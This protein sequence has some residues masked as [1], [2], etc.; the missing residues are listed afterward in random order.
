M[1]SL[2]LAA[3]TGCGDPIELP[4]AAVAA[5]RSAH[6]LD[7]PFPSDELLVDGRID[8]TL[9][10]EA[11]SDIGE[12]MIRGWAEQA[13][14]AVTGFSPLAAIY[15]RF[16]A[17]LDVADRYPGDPGDPIRLYSLD[18]GDQVP[19][20]VRF[21]ED[22]G[23]DPYL[24]EDLL[25]IAPDPAHPLRSGER[26]AAVV[27][28]TLAAPAEGWTRPPEIAH[29]VAAA[30]IFTVQDS[31]GQLRALR[32]AAD[33]ALDADPSLLEPLDLRQVVGLSF[34][35]STTP[36]GEPATA[37]TAHF[38]DGGEEVT[39]LDDRDTLEDWSLDLS[40]DPMAIWQATIH[41]VAFQDLSE[42][43]Y[44]SPGIGLL[45]D[46]ARR[47]DGWIDFDAEG[48]P[49]AT[50]APE[51][52]R[53]VLQIPKTGGGFPVITWDHGTG[54]HAYSAVQRIG[55]D[56]DG[57][58]VRADLAAGGV[59]VVSRDQPL[60]GQRYPLIDEGFTGSLGFYNIGNLP[61]FRDNQRQGAVD[62]W[63]LHRFTRDVLPDYFDTNPDRIGAFG[64]SLGS[65]TAHLGLALAGGDGAESSLMSGTGGYFTYYILE[66]GLL[67][68]GSN[69]TVVEQLGPLLG[70]D[71]DP[72]AGA[73]ELLG[74]LLGLPDE[75][76]AR[77][78]RFHPVL[79]LFQVIMDGSDALAVARHQVT[80]ETIVLGLED[81]QVP[82]VTTRWLADATPDAEVIECQRQDEYD[83][84]YCTFR[85][86]AG[87]SSFGDY[88]ATLRE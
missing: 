46:F 55:P 80:P 47:G 41:T 69:N 62:R 7:R 34:A 71:L 86:E 84:H 26:Y 54:G 33:A 66:T 65:V 27:D 8:Y 36:S 17:P 13:S 15:L 58:R 63:V 72:D 40:D 23:G 1:L 77:V 11:D 83:G 73:S 70:E 51:P 87:L 9:L 35:Q 37:V 3:L 44:A 22:P 10:P 52:M 39:Y 2:L 76:R 79:G 57:A 6:W 30:T 4:R 60:Y 29:D 82:E 43:P 78:D 56:D 64:H 18:S 81:L 59:A 5:D 42:Q 19:V 38:A 74:A 25:V 21:Y 50:P 24:A 31:L 45:N 49:L 85:E 12:L 16:E 28:T 61:C 20:D 32:D 14:E 68:G 75:A 48:N 53:I 67:S 88:A